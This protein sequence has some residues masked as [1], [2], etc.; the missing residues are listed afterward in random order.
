M[1][2][3]SVAEIISQQSLAEY[4]CSNRDNIIELPFEIHFDG[5]KTGYSVDGQQCLLWVE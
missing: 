3:S 2:D 4:L 5:K 1:H